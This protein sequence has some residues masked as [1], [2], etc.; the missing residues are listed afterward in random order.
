MKML[1]FLGTLLMEEIPFPTTWDVR[2]LVNNEI[3]STTNL[4]W[5]K[6]PDFFHHLKKQ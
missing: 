1:Q 3:R 6:P 2:H 5:F 4:N